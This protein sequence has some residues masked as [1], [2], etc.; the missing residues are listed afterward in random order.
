VAQHN[1]LDQMR[2]TRGQCPGC[3]TF[4]AAQDARLNNART[5]S[6]ERQIAALSEREAARWHHLRWCT[7][8]RD[9]AMLERISG[10]CDT[11]TCDL[12][13]DHASDH[14]CGVCG[15]NWKARR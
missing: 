6:A 7:Q 1:H 9:V 3:D 12:R 10:G 5:N 11:H 14:H 13:P 2:R 15:T 8:I 4:W